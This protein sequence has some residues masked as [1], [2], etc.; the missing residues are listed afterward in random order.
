MSPEQ[1]EEMGN[2]GQKVV[3]NKFTYEHLAVEFLKSI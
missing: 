1:R 2:K 3:I